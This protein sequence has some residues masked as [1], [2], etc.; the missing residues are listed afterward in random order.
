MTHELKTWP[1]YFEEVFMGRKT[2]EVRQNDRDYKNG[3]TLILKEFDNKTQ[4]Y[5]GRTIARTV[6]YVLHGG[7]FGIAKD[8]VV[9]SIQ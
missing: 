7:N 5:T 3:D 4:R 9:M 8:T 6:T 1:E 2:F